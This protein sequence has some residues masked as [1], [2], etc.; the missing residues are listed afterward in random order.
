MP[1]ETG[2]FL[3]VRKNNAE[4]T[5]KLYT[6][7][8]ST[9]GLA[10]R[11]GGAIQYARLAPVGTIGETSIRMRKDNVVYSV[12]SQAIPANVTLSTYCVGYTL[13]AVVSD[14][15]GGSNNVWIEDNSVDGCNYQAAS[16]ISVDITGPASSTTT[17]DNILLYINFTGWDLV[18][19]PMGGDGMV[20][21]IFGSDNQNSLYTWGWENNR[22]AVGQGDTSVFFSITRH[23][24]GYEGIATGSIYCLEYPEMGT[25]Y[26]TVTVTIP[27]PAIPPTHYLT[28]NSATVSPSVITLGNS[29]TVT[30]NHDQAQAGDWIYSKSGIGLASPFSF[31]HHSDYYAAAIQPVVGSYTT[32]FPVSSSLSYSSIVPSIE[33]I[34]VSGRSVIG[35]GIIAT[36]TVQVL[37]VTVA[38]P[39]ATFVG[40]WNDFNSTSAGFTC[41]TYSGTGISQ[42]SVDS[43]WWGHYTCNEW[44]VG[45]CSIRMYNSSGT[46]IG[47]FNHPTFLG[48]YGWSPTAPAGWTAPYGYSSS[49]GQYKGF[50]P[51][52][53]GVWGSRTQSQQFT[54]HFLGVIL[55]PTPAAWAAEH[56]PIPFGPAYVVDSRSIANSSGIITHVRYRMSMLRNVAATYTVASLETDL[57]Q[58]TDSAIF[59]SGM[60][61]VNNGGS[62]G[63]GPVE[64]NGCRTLY[65][66][67]YPA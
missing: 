8:L 61:T 60:R 40:Q 49:G 28:V 31:Y 6:T 21:F 55:N 13:W 11:K 52:N 30:V 58:F 42:L 17:D 36:P 63:G 14:G 46:V 23:F 18:S 9:P 39:T 1:I 65:S 7:Q 54:Q 47:Q 66:N 45:I 32:S 22:I 4:Q 3:K 43:A 50:V 25:V 48:M 15:F 37:P 64:V 29:I 62:G 53:S 24:G 67:A 51:G 10:V 20:S 12:M 44:A 35:Y 57:F 33:D 16:L 59:D 5:V 38:P 2:N 27:P 26:D 56:H 19:H 34:F 41:Y